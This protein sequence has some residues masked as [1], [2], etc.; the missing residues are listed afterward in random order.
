MFDKNDSLINIIYYRFRLFKPYYECADK[1]LRKG[2]KCGHLY[3]N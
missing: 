3:F 2:P 1:S